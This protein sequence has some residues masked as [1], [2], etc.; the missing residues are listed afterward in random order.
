MKSIDQPSYLLVHLYTPHS[1]RVNIDEKTGTLKLGP[2]DPL[3][4]QVSAKIQQAAQELNNIRSEYASYLG[5]LRTLAGC[6][7]QSSATCSRM[8]F[9]WWLT[10]LKR[11]LPH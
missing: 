6:L 4:L 3:S 10:F 7:L 5:K 11:K 2:I 8:K 1:I 9:R